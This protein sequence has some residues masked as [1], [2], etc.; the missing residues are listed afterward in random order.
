MFLQQVF[1][2]SSSCS[3]KE[4]DASCYLFSRERRD[5]VSTAWS[6]LHLEPRSRCTVEIL[7]ALLPPPFIFGGKEKRG[8]GQRGRKKQMQHAPAGLNWHYVICRSCISA[9]WWHC[10]LLYPISSNPC[11]FVNFVSD[12]II[13]RIKKSNWPLKTN[14]LTLLQSM[15]LLGFS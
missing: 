11:Q 6:H 7:H 13:W 14:I 4:L 8:L 2:P 1:S 15:W 12:L 5:G 3:E 10:R 9:R